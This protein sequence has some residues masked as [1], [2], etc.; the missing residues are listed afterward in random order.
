MASFQGMPDM[1]MLQKQYLSLNWLSL[2]NYTSLVNWWFQLSNSLMLNTH[3]D[4]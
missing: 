2:Y 1:I 3:D 4:W